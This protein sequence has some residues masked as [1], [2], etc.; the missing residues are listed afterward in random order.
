[1]N[2]EEFNAYWE[3]WHRR[4]CPIC[5]PEGRGIMHDAPTKEQTERFYFQYKMVRAEDGLLYRVPSNP[6][7]A[8]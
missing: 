5:V 2:A 8:N 7:I 1:M 3:D 6:G 4:E